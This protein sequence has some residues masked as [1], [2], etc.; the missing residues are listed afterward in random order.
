MD[1]LGLLMRARRAGLL[2]PA[3]GERALSDV[4]GAGL[5]VAAD[6]VEAVRRET[7]RD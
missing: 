1:T 5:W 7:L 6:A 2:E 3:E 4:V